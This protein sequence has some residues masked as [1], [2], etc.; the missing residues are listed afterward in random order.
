MRV[1]SEGYIKRR[2]IFANGNY[3][4]IIGDGVGGKEK[5]RLV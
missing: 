5:L 2:V 1:A 3:Y 4:L